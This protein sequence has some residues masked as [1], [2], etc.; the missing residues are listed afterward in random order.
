MVPPTYSQMSATDGRFAQDKAFVRNPSGHSSSPPGLVVKP[1]FA[2][3]ILL[4]IFITLWEKWTGDVTYRVHRRLQH[5]PLVIIQACNPLPCCL[6]RCQPF[7]ALVLAFLK[8][9]HTVKEVDLTTRPHNYDCSH[10]MTL[11]TWLSNFLATVML[12]DGANSKA[13]PKKTTLLSV[14]RW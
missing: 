13:W 5:H 11:A 12:C 14:A 7:L 2:T 4:H 3:T 1:R 6:E 9:T 10:G 8:E